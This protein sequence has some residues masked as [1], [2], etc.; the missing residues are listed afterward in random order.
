MD[1]SMDHLPIPHMSVLSSS[2][3]ESHDFVDS[4][5]PAASLA[6][7]AAF[8]ANGFLCDVEIE[9]ED[10]IFAAHRC[11]LA[12]SIPYFCSMFSSEMRESRQ[13]RIIIQDI[14]AAAFE[15]LIDF[16]YTS[17]VQITGANVQQLLYAAS[18]LQIDSVCAAC[19]RF[20]T[21][22]L[23]VSNCLS[24]RHFAEQHNCV[25]L[26]QSVDEFAVDHFQEL[27]KS[28]EF[29]TIPLSHLMDLV[30][31]GDLR[32]NSEQEVFETVVQW[33]AHGLDTRKIYLPDLL[34]KVRLAQ[35]PT[36][37]LLNEVKNH[38]LIQDCI[39]CR[40]LVSDAMSEKMRSHCSSMSPS[41][42]HQIPSR[43]RKTAAGVIFC[44]G[45]RGTS[46]DPFRTVE[47]YD[48]RRDKWFPVTEMNVRRR[49]VGVVSAQGKLYAI[50]GHDGTNHLESAECFDPATNMWHSVQSMETR[51]RGIAVG[52]LEGA[53]YAV[54]GLDDTA[55]FQTVERYDVEAN[56]W[57]AVESMNIQRGG[58]GVAALSKYLFAVGGNDGTSSLD[59]C[60]RYDPLLNKWKL[61]DSMAHRRAGAGVTVLD[62]CLYAIGGFDDN[63]PLN[64]C[65]R[66]CPEENKW[67]LL[68]PMSCPRGGVGVAAMGGRIY[69]IGGHDGLR[70]LDS[71]ETYDPLTNQW[72]PVA[73]ISQCRAGA[74]V[75]WCACR[76][77]ELLKPPT[78]A[79]GSGC[80]PSATGGA[81]AY[82]V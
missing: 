66:Y 41:G 35:L 74:G 23:T 45:G 70:Y 72:T 30:K 22:Y 63:A 51:R 49:H 9:V 57:S 67:V 81:V 80:A 47:A 20:L 37:Y 71:V 5:H 12:A 59:S 50:G 2:V 17:K 34:D 55:C 29:L 58:V 13:S 62:G 1:D 60:E 48:W 10:S 79:Q 46:G 26:M 15:L 53:I 14:P 33:V 76:V 68:P 6:H 28:S 39:R 19:Q 73:S 4:T 44:V 69:A 54:G 8:R 21:Q 24:I 36:N 25:G 78:M 38:P 18:I 52:S 31:S 61:V 3:L 43:P 40:D 32:V 77:D 11:V 65:E 82:C 56:K 42:A 7:L 64:S 27:R 16:A 75:A